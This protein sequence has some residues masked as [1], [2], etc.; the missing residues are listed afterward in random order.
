M[1]LLPRYTTANLVNLLDEIYRTDSKNTSLPFSYSRCRFIPTDENFGKLEF[2]LAG[3]SKDEIEVYTERNALFVS[4]K[5]KDDRS[6]F[7]S[8]PIAENERIGQVKYE[9][10]LLVIEIMKIV[11]E[12]QRRKNYQIE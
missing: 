9:N 1:A 3:Y 11:P 4:A 12:Q 2:E 8:W 5:K 7:R 10:G 6:Y